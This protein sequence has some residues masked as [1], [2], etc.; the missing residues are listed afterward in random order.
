MSNDDDQWGWLP[1]SKTLYLL[2]NINHHY[3]HWSA[4]V[5]DFSYFF[6]V[7][8]NEFY[9][10]LLSAKLTYTRHCFAEYLTEQTCWIALSC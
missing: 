3:R 4:G 6:Y 2:H 10:V 7:K 8:I 5:T 9:E 1:V